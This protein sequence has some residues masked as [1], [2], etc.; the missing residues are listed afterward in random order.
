MLPVLLLGIQALKINNTI[1]PAASFFVFYLELGGGGIGSTLVL[2]LLL[3]DTYR[4]FDVN[5]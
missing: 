5:S 2:V 4:R 1:W 3:F